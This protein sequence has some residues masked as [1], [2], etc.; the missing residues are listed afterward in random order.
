M[1]IDGVADNLGV[2]LLPMFTLENAIRA[3]RV[4]TFTVKNF[5]ISMQ[6]QVVHKKNRWMSPALKSFIENTKEFI[7]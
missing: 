2:S 6:M 4:A 5:N 7:V 1:I 3:N